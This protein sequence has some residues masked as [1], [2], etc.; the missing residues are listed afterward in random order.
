MAAKQHDLVLEFGI[1]T[2][3]LRVDVVD[4]LVIAELVD[5]FEFHLDFLAFLDQTDHTGVV[6]DRHRQF[7]NRFGVAR[8]V[9]DARAAGNIE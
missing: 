8:L 9:V 2:G 4:F 5:E 3:N 1:G 7:G 6:F